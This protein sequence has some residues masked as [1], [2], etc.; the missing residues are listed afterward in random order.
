VNNLILRLMDT[1]QVGS[2][3]LPGATYFPNSPASETNLRIALG[4]SGTPSLAYVVSLCSAV[5]SFS[6]LY[7]LVDEQINTWEMLIP[8]ERQQIDWDS[9]YDKLKNAST[10]WTGILSDT[11]LYKAFFLAPSALEG[12]ATA[13]AALA[14]HNDDVRLDNG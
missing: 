11:G 14:F 12:V 5:K 6:W 9:L 13:V 8:A 1:P 7:C 2:E 10:G 3:S 4:I